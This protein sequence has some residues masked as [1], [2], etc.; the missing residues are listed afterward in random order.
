MTDADGR[1]AH[2]EQPPSADLLRE[3]RIQRNL[4]I[5]VVGLGVL[6]LVGLGAV[7]VR[8]LTFA[9]DPQR[10]TATEGGVTLSQNGEIG[11]ELPRDAKVVSISVSGDRLAIHHD[12][13][14]GTGITVIDLA[15]GRR[16]ADIK[17]VQALP[18]N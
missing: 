8:I 15:T 3:Q 9:N 16:I 2:S 1:A 6:I 4:K 5:L 18:R 12:G 14:G 13:P 7:A 10:P 11:I 17:P